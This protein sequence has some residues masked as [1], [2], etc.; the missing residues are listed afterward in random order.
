[1][2]KV[3]AAAA[4]EEEVKQ[5]VAKELERLH[6]AS[7]QGLC[8]EGT[9]RVFYFSGYSVPSA[10]NNTNQINRSKYCTYV[11]YLT[12]LCKALLLYIIINYSTIKRYFELGTRTVLK[13]E[14]SSTH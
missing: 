10:R 5:C 14:N 9:N 2:D 8:K 12:Y 13:Y 6:Q 3:A 4:F 1:M 7:Q 11:H